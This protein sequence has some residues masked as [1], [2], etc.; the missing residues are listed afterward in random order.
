VLAGPAAD[1]YFANWLD[2]TTFKPTLRMENSQRL[3]L[4]DNAAEMQPPILAQRL[5]LAQPVIWFL[6]LPNLDNQ[7]T[8]QR[9]SRNFPLLDAQPY[10][11]D[12]YTVMLYSFGRP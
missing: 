12:G 7:S 4:M 3:F 10:G 11:D 1:F 2:R 9:L 6:A 5:P 8:L